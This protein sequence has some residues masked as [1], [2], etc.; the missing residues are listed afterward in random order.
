MHAHMSQTQMLQWATIKSLRLLLYIN[1]AA[2]FPQYAASPCLT[3]RLTL[4]ST[5]SDL[6]QTLHISPAITQQLINMSA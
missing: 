1:S 6:N 5:G 4:P 2:V 3:S